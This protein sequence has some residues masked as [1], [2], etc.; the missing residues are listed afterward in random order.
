M[1]VLNLTNVFKVAVLFALFSSPVLAAS[2]NKDETEKLAGLHY[3]NGINKD[4]IETASGL[5]YKALI[6]GSGYMLGGTD[7]GRRG[8]VIQ[9]Y[10]GA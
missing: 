10:P 8:D 1:G 5:K 6:A 9:A 4:V 2:E 3:W 7:G